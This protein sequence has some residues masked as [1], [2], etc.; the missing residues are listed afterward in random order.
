MAELTSAAINDL[1]DSAFAYIEGGGTK[2]ASG[3]TVPRDKRHFPVHD[4]DHVRN[5]LSRA[6]QSPFGDKAM[7]KIRAAAKKFGIDVSDGDSGSGRAESMTSFER[8]FPL[9][10]LSVRSGKEGRIVSAY[11]AVFDT[12]A[13]VDDQDGK[14]YEVIDRAAFSKAISDGRPQGNRRAWGIGVFYNHGRTICGTPSEMASMPIGVPI[15]ITTDDVGVLTETQ[16]H[17]SEFAENVVEGLES[18]AI[19]GYSF[20]GAFRRSSPPIPRGGFRRT[21]DRSEFPTVRRLEST[22][23]EYGPTPL[24]VYKEAAVVGMRAE[25]LLSAMAADP[26]LAHRVISMLSASTPGEPLPESGTPSGEEPPPR[27][28][29]VHSGRSVKQ[30]MNAARSAFLQRQHRS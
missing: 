22:L 9:K 17:R 14:Y 10:D 25:V 8:S 27:S 12:P 15:D 4:A 5:A 30:E 6:P 18:G 23:R 21:A 19:P 7:P 1:P 24:P 3:R 28:R 2:D 26:D 13:F 11:A 29:L 16:Y 20:S